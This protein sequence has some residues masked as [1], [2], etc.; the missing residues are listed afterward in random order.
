MPKGEWRDRPGE[1]NHNG[2]IIIYAYPTKSMELKVVCNCGQKFVFDV[3]PLNGRMP[4]P[5]NCPACGIDATENAN[6]AIALKIAAPPSVRMTV[7]IPT[8]PPP[9]AGGI[10][11]PPPPNS[12]PSAAPQSAGGLR[13]NK[14]AH[15]ESP[16]AASVPAPL[17]IQPNPSRPKPMTHVPTYTPGYLKDNPALQ[18]NNFM[19]GILGAFIGAILGLA[20]MF[21]LLIFLGFSIPYTGVIIGALTGFGARI[22]YRG[23]D[24]TLGAAAAAV[25]FFVVGGALYFLYVRVGYFDIYFI[26]SWIVAVGSAFKIASG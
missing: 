24:Y 15:T 16:Q 20:F 18:N 19:L 6:S 11:I 3:E 13:I 10:P 17:P 23:T 12:A 14:P 25:A 4:M 22:F 7:T 9:S 21:G 5:I 26:F 1:D 2:A 8:P